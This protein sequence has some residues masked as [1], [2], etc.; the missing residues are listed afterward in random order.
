MLK[1]VRRASLL[2][3]V[4]LIGA[5][6]AA[7]A[8]SACNPGRPATETYRYFDGSNT[9]PTFDGGRCIIGSSS[10]ITVRNPYVQSQYSTAWTGIG[11]PVSDEI[12]Q[13]GPMNVLPN[14]SPENF[15]EWATGEHINQMRTWTHATVGSGPNY[16][17]LW[18]GN[19]FHIDYNGSNRY[20][21][22]D[23][24]YAGCWAQDYAEIHN[25]NTQTPGVA[26]THESFL[27][28]QLVEFSSGG[29]W[30]F[31]NAS[32]WIHGPSSEGVGVF[33]SPAIACSGGSGAACSTDYSVG[34]TGLSL[35][36]GVHF[37]GT[38]ITS[39]QFYTESWD[40]CR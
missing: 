37:S 3:V 23:S 27:P 28:G 21:W 10:D 5:G 26:A 25:T 22:S 31:I 18:S 2:E 17:V 33:P 12:I 11:N 4:L 30:Q 15:A 40:M 36:N 1:L 39:P 24:S 9:G 32:N 35:T 6:L 19:S 13:S 20:N 38:D 8:A 16:E 14:Y 29:G 7:A 34:G